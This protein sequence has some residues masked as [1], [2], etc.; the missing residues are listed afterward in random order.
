[1]F[2]RNKPRKNYRKSRRA[3]RQYKFWGRFMLLFKMMAAVAAV[4]VVT[5]FFVLLHDILTQCNFFAIAKVTIEGTRLLTPAQVARQARVRM[6]DNILSVNL[7]LVRKR[8]LAHPWIAEAEVTREIP[9]RLIIRIKEHSAMAVVDF[10]QKF[11][12]NLQGRI[13]KA[14]DPAD[15]VNLPVISGL[16]VSD[17]RVYGQSET[18]E[19]SDRQL[20]SAPFKAVMQALQLGRQQGSILP[21]RLVRQINVD[22]QIGLTVYAFDRVKAIYLGYGDYTSKYHMLANILSY[23]KRQ[24]SIMDFDRIDLNNLKRVVVNPIRTESR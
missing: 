2:N 7:S 23:L 16:D 1:M 8:L 15:K 21:N 5:G 11:L 19:K 10:G 17:L 9:A 14:W 20:N 24:R 12:I 13:F 4:V 18:P 6:G 3:K 22:R